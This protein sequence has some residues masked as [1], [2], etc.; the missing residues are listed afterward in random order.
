MSAPF[1]SVIIPTFNRC[2]LL[3][4]AV[5][6]VVAQNFKSFEIII[7]DNY[8]KDKTQKIIKD[9]KK[10]NI[11]YKKIK[12]RGIISKSRNKGM[13]IAKGKWIAF[14]D[15]DDTWHEDKL[16]NIYNNIKKKNIEVICN[17][18][19]AIKKNSDEKNIWGY[20]PYKKGFYRHLLESENCLSI[21][22]SVVKKEF[23]KRN[24]ISFSEKKK[25]VRSE[26]FDFFLNIALKGG[27]FYFLH[28]PLGNHLFHSEQFSH[29]ELKLKNSFKAVAQHHI[30]KVQNYSKRKRD[31]WNKVILFMKFRYL[32]SNLRKDKTSIN[33]IK[34]IS[35]FFLFNPFFSLLFGYKLFK[36]RILGIYLTNKFLILSK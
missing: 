5:E 6:S 11:I 24:K 17:D 35:L 31:I 10:K 13:E 25:F 30:Y 3:K 32:I 20:G 4:R 29:N 2:D 23:L 12:N 19:W 34:K 27:I 7:V 33:I 28:L 15:S 14:L 8:S 36:R 9:F 16:E 22:A 18:E 21:S 26:D 1:F